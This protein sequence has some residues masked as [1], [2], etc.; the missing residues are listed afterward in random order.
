MSELVIVYKNNSY[1]L[2]LIAAYRFE[3][4]VFI[5]K[6][7]KKDGNF[8]SIDGFPSLLLALDFTQ[9]FEIAL[10]FK[11]DRITL[12]NLTRSS[13]EADFSFI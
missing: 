11:A 6:F 8:L 12:S 13:A 2:V 9:I 4:I 5:L 1:S 10:L 3:L 7:I